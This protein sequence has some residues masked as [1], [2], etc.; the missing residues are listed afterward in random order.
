MRI[1]FMEVT[2][3][4]LL[5][6]AALSITPACASDAVVTTIP[7]VNSVAD[8]AY[9]AKRGVIYMTDQNHILRY[10]VTAGAYLDPIVLAGGP[11]EGMDISPDGNT[12]A[13]ADADSV[14]VKV[15]LV[16]LGSGQDTVMSAAAHDYEGGTHEVAYTREGNLIVSS[17]YLGSGWVP[18]RK[19]DVSSGT[20]AELASVRL[21][22]MLSSS[23]D[24]KIV[25]FAE[26]DISNGP[27][28]FYNAKSGSLVHFDWSGGT[29]NTFNYGITTNFDGSQFT[30]N[31]GSVYNPSGQGQITIHDGGLYPAASANDPVQPTGYFA[32]ANSSQVR[33]YDMQT[34]MPLGS[35]DFG[36]AFTYGGYYGDLP[37]LRIS[38]DGSMLIARFADSVR[39]LRLCDPLAADDLTT[40]TTGS[41]VQIE[42]QGHLGN[43]R[44]LSYGIEMPPAHGKVFV[45]GSVATYAP[46][47]GYSGQDSF[48]YA[49]HYGLAVASATVRV[50]VTADN[51]AYTPVVSFDT[52]PVLQ[53]TTPVPGSKRIPGDFNGD[54]TSD[55]LWFNPKYSQLGYWSMTSTAATVRRSGAKTFNITPG[56]FIGAVGDFGG[57]GYADLM[58]TSSSRDL[59]LWTNDHAGGWSSK[60][61]YSYPAAWQ[62]V[63]AGDVDGDGKDDLLW[64]DPS[65]C[66]FAYWLMD[67]AVRKGAKTFNIACGYY[68]V[69]VGYYTPSNRISV[70]W[71]S[72][73]NDLYVWDA[74]GGGFS[75]YNLTGAMQ[76]GD[77]QAGLENIWALGGGVAGHDIGLEWNAQ[78]QR[79]GVGA[80]LTRSFD[81]QG[82]QT[83]YRTQ[84]KWAGGLWMDD[85]IAAGYLIQSGS[86]GL[87]ALDA[88]TLSVQTGGLATGD[89]A[90]S[91]SAPR[92]LATEW[93]YPDGWYTVGGPNNPGMALPWR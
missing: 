56:Y 57:D 8:V 47:P 9:D 64:L 49:V 24:G 13:V 60:Q 66:Q 76:A 3:G 45:K 28:G 92:T 23:G 35:Y 61:S 52:L 51:S 7:T 79:F 63:G 46:A 10:D 32:M 93:S 59:W 90:V 75:S 71:S 25:G 73:A 78:D 87:Y 82:N 20:F 42:L 31:G 67:G 37:S 43:V 6:S 65:D 83:S 70:L 18:L 55:L 62:L 53:A 34:Y 68:P 48:T 36:E 44:K 40:S 30:L 16:N 91:G 80:T 2:A 72:A 5:L 33:S 26:P 84:L 22:T 89:A 74:R 85:P 14:T 19:L 1:K 29:T 58:F 88:K 54:G 27:W 50:D 15:H 21:N 77:Y 39:Y 11:L 69:G 17:T 86:T 81:S 4:S 38:R 41:R 12:L